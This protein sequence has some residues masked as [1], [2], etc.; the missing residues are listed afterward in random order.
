MNQISLKSRLYCFFFNLKKC[1]S[2]LL[3]KLGE[4]LHFPMTTLLY[5]GSLIIVVVLGMEINVAGVV[6]IVS[7]LDCITTRKLRKFSEAFH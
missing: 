3:V 7:F 1:L 2:Q 5:S 4:L 6:M